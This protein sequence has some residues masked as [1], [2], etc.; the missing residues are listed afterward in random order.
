MYLPKFSWQYLKDKSP[1]YR[2][3]FQ[4][5]L[6]SAASA[7]RKIVG[8]TIYPRQANQRIDNK[9]Y[10]KVP[11]IRSECPGLWL[12]HRSGSC[13]CAKEP[14]CRPRTCYYYRRLR[15]LVS[16]QQCHKQPV[17][18]HGA[19]NSNH[20]IYLLSPEGITSRCWMEK[21]FNIRKYL[22]YLNY[23]YIIFIG[24]YVGPNPRI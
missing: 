1:C 21:L 7:V 10:L 19:D 4:K 20:L 3:D 14:I 18:C 13:R 6:S 9:A 24:Y 5:A 8:R 11:L 2:E 16:G 12:F 22:T 17:D 23:P 15:P